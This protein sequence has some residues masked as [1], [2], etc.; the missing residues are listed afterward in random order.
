MDYVRSWSARGRSQ[1]ESSSG[2]SKEFSSDE[3]IDSSDTDSSD[4]D[5][6]SKSEE[7][8]KSKKM[9]SKKKKQKTISTA[10]KY[11]KH[12]KPTDI[13]PIHNGHKW[14]KC[15][16]NRQSQGNQSRGRN[17]QSQGQEQHN[18]G[19]QYYNNEQQQVGESHFNT[20]HDAQIVQPSVILPRPSL[21]VTQIMGTRS[22]HYSS[23]SH[24]PTT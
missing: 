3:D 14:A 17:N 12:L 13:C 5:S 10:G 16:L 18:Q 9:K 23:Y 22:S 15:R 4:S 7:E 21:Y 20:P 11:G 1:N 6:D 2:D 24:N 19:Q 8:K